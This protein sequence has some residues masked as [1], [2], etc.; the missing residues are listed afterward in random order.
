MVVTGF[1][2]EAIRAALEGDPDYAAAGV[3]IVFAHNAEFEKA[4]GISV[5]VGGA[6]LTGP[7]VLSMADHMYTPAIARTVAGADMTAA[8]L[9]LA[10]DV[11]T[12]D[13]LD[14]DDATKVAS[15]GGFKGFSRGNPVLEDGV[16]VAGRAGAELIQEPRNVQA[17][18]AGG[19]AF[20]DEPHLMRD[21][22]DP[23]VLQMEAEREAGQAVDHDLGAFQGAE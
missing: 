1:R 6:V 12:G 14:I 18:F 4:N 16:E 13:I 23:E 20:N 9:Y 5:M 17:S 7:F 21:S 2:A 10:T 11:R 15:E 19:A 3:E 22:L 8:D